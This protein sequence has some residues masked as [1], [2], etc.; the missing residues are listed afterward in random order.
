MFNKYPLNI[1]L[2]MNGFFFF[3]AC[4]LINGMYSTTELQFLAE[5][6]KFHQLIYIKIL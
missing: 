3:F 4:L 1:H 2:L 6:I 5:F